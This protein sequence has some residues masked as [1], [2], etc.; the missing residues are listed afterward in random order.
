MVQIASFIAVAGMMAFIMSLG[1]SDPRLY[2]AVF[3]VLLILSVPFGLLP[4]AVARH[5]GRV[6]WREAAIAGLLAGG[7]FGII[8]FLLQ[9]G[10]TYSSSAGGVALW[11]DGWPTFAGLA[12]S[13]A[14][15]GLYAAIGG[16][17]GLLLR[18]LVP[19]DLL[20]ASRFPLR[21][22]WR[23]VLPL[24]LAI[25]ALAAVP[26]TEQATR[27]RSCFNP[28]RAGD[29]PRNVTPNLSLRLHVS[30]SQWP[31]VASSF[32]AFAKA[33]GWRSRGQTEIREDWNWFQYEACREPVV[34]IIILQI[35]LDDAG[36]LIVSVTTERPEI[37]WEADV[38]RLIGLLARHGRITRDRLMVTRRLPGWAQAIPIEPEAPPIPPSTA[39]PAA[40]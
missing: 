18:A 4:Y 9:L 39:A 13:A 24:A 21:P 8:F 2:P 11:K 3:A 10:G 19:S 37:T 22:Y 35:P 17:G 14:L 34:N 25:A 7:L 6:G 5:A 33:N 15:C 28:F 12:Q 31:D 26:I 32:A 38:Q 16:L 23:D 27:D 29:A 30:K 1:F 20:M 36:G 40:R